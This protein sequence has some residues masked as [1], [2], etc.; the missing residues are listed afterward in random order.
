[1]AQVHTT[2]CGGR[3]CRYIPS[4]ILRTHYAPPRRKCAPRCPHRS[5]HSRHIPHSRHRQSPE[6][7]TSRTAASAPA[8]SYTHPSRS[9]QTPKP[10]SQSR[11]QSHVN[12]HERRLPTRTE[13][14]RPEV[15]HRTDASE[16]RKEAATHVPDDS[17]HH[18]PATRRLATPG[19]QCHDEE[20]CRSV[21]AQR[22]LEALCGVWAR[23]MKGKNV[24]GVEQLRTR[25]ELMLAMRHIASYVAWYQDEERRGAWKRC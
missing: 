21:R 4:I 5:A 1:M 17:R 14:L 7:Q 18:C 25:R 2:A 10:T 19:N 3:K 9:A 24:C 20:W 22:V 15:I 23:R 11:D 6:A 13:K 12:S 16:D 8:N